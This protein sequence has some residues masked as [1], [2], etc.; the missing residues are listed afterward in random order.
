[1]Q[2]ISCQHLFPR[3]HRPRPIRRGFK[4]D[5]KSAA[6]LPKYKHV[7]SNALKLNIPVLPCV[8]EVDKHTANYTCSGFGEKCTASFLA[9]KTW[10]ALQI[11]GLSHSAGPSREE[12]WVSMFLCVIVCQV[13][14]QM[15][16]SEVLRFYDTLLCDRAWPPV[17]I[18]SPPCIRLDLPD[19][20]CSSNTRFLPMWLF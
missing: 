1:M 4:R 20:N 2:I 14:R 17:S 13:E 9:T 6:V 12:F 18:I 15:A 10:F 7:A 16:V 8:N 19:P 11:K 5:C 3:N